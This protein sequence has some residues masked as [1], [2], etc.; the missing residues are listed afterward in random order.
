MPSAAMIRLLKRHVQP[1]SRVLDVGCGLGTNAIWMAQHRYEVQGVDVSATAISQA[2]L[3]ARRAGVVAEFQMM[4]FLAQEGWQRPFDCV[5]D[6]GCLHSF[7]TAASRSLFARR[8]WEA[9]SLGGLWISISGS[10]DNQDSQGERERFGYPRL[11]VAD[12]A[13][14]AERMFEVLEI[15]R[16]EYGNK[17]E[18]R[19]LAF[20][21]LLR[22]RQSLAGDDESAS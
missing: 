16:C 5:V 21:S 13:A 12:I 14:A 18:A 2:R 15:R 20:A 19:F 9:L 4:E 17:D 7:L 11:S 10:C 6:R 22:R 1:G 3:K 8:V